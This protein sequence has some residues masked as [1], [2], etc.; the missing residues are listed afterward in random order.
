MWTVNPAND[1]LEGLINYICKNAQDYFG[2]AGLHYRLEAPAQLPAVIIS[3]ELRH[4]VF[5]AAKEAVTNVVRHA[6][7]KSVWVRL[8]LT[9]EE[10]VLE[11]A[12]DGCGPAGKG[13]RSGRNGLLNM[14]RR[15][16]DVGGS[17]HIGPAPEGGT[18][19]RLTAPLKPR[20]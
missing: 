2:V 12:D 13:A 20:T 3:P 18:V 6:R 11:I 16:E 5:L 4:N 10:F 19:V 8:R 1:T 9:P 15:M 14:R 7:A 17:F